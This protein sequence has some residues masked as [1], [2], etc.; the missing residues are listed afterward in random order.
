MLISWSGRRSRYQLSRLGEI[1]R[2]SR[3]GW[4]PVRVI[5]GS[6]LRVVRWRRWELTRWAKS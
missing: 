1:Y 4:R 5:D 3:T 6:V 2:F